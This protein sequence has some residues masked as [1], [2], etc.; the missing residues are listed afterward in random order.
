MEALALSTKIIARRLGDEMVVV[1]LT[2]EQV[3][4]LSPSAA[5]CWELLVEG[6]AST[7]ISD[8]LAEHFDVD[9]AT[10][11]RSVEEFIGR[12]RAAGLVEGGS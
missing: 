8:K 3:Y 1:N 9:S 10:A 11:R 12:L 6:V 7:E 2:D 5:R 4:A